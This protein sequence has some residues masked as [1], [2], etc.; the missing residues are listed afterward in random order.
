MCQNNYLNI[1]KVLRETMPSPYLQ[2]Y[3]EDLT[4]GWNLR[5]AHFRVWLS[6]LARIPGLLAL[7]STRE[8]EQFEVTQDQKGYLK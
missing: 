2:F 3:M 4:L 6:S 8:A 7:D 1:L 5:A